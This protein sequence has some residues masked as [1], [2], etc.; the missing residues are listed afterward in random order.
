MHDDA[1]LFDVDSVRRLE[2][3]ARGLLGEGVLMERAGQAAWR[4]LLE[5]WPQAQRIAVACGPGGNGGDGYVLA[6]HA[7]EAGREVVAVAVDDRA[8]SHAEARDAR[9]AFRQAGGRIDVFDGT[10]PA[11]DVVVDAVL[12]IGMSGAPTGA[13]RALIDTVRGCDAPVLAL[14]VPSG[15]AESHVD[16]ATVRADATIEFLLPKLMTRTGA[17]QD[18]CGRLMLAR[19]DVPAAV[20]DAIAPAAIALRVADLGRLLPPRRRDSHKGDH[21]RVL[22]MGGDHGSGGAIL[23]CAEAALRTGA[24]LVRVHTRG[25]HVAPLLA[26]VP[27]AMASAEALDVGW[28]DVIA[29]GPGLGRG[30]W[31]QAVFDAVLAQSGSLVLDADALNLLADGPRTLPTDCVLTPHPGEAAR[32]LGCSTAEVQ[33][34]RAAALHALVERHRCAVVLK[35]AGTLVGAPGRLPALIDAGGPAL[36]S[37]GTGDVLTGVIAALRGQGL[38]TFDAACAG[39]LLHAVAGDA[40]ASDGVRGLRASDLM[41]HLRRLA[42]P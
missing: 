9:A 14:D 13:V 28:P 34:H 19:L 31:S 20:M 30:P 7:L 15:L 37:G 3:S 10:L 39:A 12:G 26:R 29:I 2:R 17:A 4:A 32:L 27:E 25:E 23:L 33:R 6:R 36:A 18:A 42:N 22:C 8:P 41:P 11:A 35:G 1:A 40:A 16:G 21:G 5:H 24:G 38:E